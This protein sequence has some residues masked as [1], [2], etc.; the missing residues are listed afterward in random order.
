[1]HLDWMR[2]KCIFSNIPLSPN[3]VSLWMQISTL[4]HPNNVFHFI[5]YSYLTTNLFFTRMIR[6]WLSR[7]REKV[8]PAEQVETRLLIEWT[9]VENFFRS[10][11]DQLQPFLGSGCLDVVM[12]IKTNVYLTLLYPVTVVVTA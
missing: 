11:A 2:S 8:A 7:S 6:S 9:L 1:M 4:F 10:C 5:C 3:P 12:Q